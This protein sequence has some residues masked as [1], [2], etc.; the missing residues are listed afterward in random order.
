MGGTILRPIECP[1][2]KSG[3]DIVVVRL[4]R[5]L[6]LL[7]HL[8]LLLLLLVYLLMLRWWL[9]RV[10]MRQN[11]VAIIMHMCELSFIHRKLLGLHGGK[12]SGNV[13]L[14]SV[15]LLLLLLFP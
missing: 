7:L 6:S 10:Y 12:G 3:L 4:L 9:R 1:I 15:K 2:L 13:K 11:I 5:P 14:L 8:L